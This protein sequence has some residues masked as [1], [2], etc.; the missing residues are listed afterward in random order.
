M[1]HLKVRSDVKLA[2]TGV[3]RQTPITSTC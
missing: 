2:G 3:M 1:Q